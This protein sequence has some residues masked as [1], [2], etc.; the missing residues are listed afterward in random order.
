[1]IPALIERRARW[2]LDT[3]GATE[4]DFGEDIPYEAGAWEQVARGERPE[5]DEPAAAIAAAFF[6]LARVEELNGR[7]DEHGRFLAAYSSLDPLDPPLERLRRKLGVEPYGWGGARFAVALST[8]VDV[9]LA[10]DAPRRAR[11]GGAAERR[12][13][14]GPRPGG[15][16]RG[17]GARGYSFAQAAR[18]RPLLALRADHE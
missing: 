2:V 12:R 17:E 13:P 1:L 3:I 14:E 6:D 15:M 16:A 10:L 9:P 11:L 18:Q 5:G 7:R 4:I 8:D